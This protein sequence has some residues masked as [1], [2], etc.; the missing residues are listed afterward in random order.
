[1]SYARA[2][3][4]L[5]ELNKLLSETGGHH[6]GRRLL[7]EEAQHLC[8][9]PV[10]EKTIA[11][12]HSIGALTRSAAR[13]EFQAEMGCFTHRRSAFFRMIEPA[14]RRTQCKTPR[15]KKLPHDR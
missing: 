11:L 10:G 9:L 2:W 3:R 13:S 4:L 8:R 12:Y 6:Y 7:G 5:D 1:M 14:R 15:S